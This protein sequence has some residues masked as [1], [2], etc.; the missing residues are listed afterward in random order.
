MKSFFTYSTYFPSFFF[1]TTHISL[2]FEVTLS[3]IQTCCRK[4][5]YSVDLS[6]NKSQKLFS[7]ILL[8][9]VSLDTCQ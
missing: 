6:Q 4:S 7:F 5:K 8:L 1:A 2:D 3:K 9:H